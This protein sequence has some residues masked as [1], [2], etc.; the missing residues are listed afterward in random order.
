[1][2]K[3]VRLALRDLRGSK[4]GLRLLAV[5]LFLGVAALAGIG[6]LSSAILTGLAERGQV[7]LGG[8]IQ[9]E[10]AQRHA[11]DAE[12]AAFAKL[13][14]LSETV[15]MRAMAITRDGERSLLYCC[16]SVRVQDMARNHHVLSVGVDLAPALRSNGLDADA[17]ID[18]I[19]R[20][21]LSRQ[22]EATIPA[23]A[24]KA[25]NAVAGIL[26]IAW[27]DDALKNPA[28]IICP[29]SSNCPR[30]EH[31]DAERGRRARDIA[32]VRKEIMEEVRHGK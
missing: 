10:A 31:C 30:T 1:M 22:G 9:A 2:K 7:I 6:S 17:V 3:A 25:I 28:R 29:R 23:P 19:T 24:A 26:G 14:T 27:L 16:H 13:G 12:R 4:A 11:T 18:S 20:A 21:C 8:D 32:D 15:S 5:C